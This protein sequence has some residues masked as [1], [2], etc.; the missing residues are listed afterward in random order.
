MKDHD[1]MGLNDRSS[2]VARLRH[3]RDMAIRM[4]SRHINGDPANARAGV[5]ALRPRLVDIHQ[6]LLNRDGRRPMAA[7]LLVARELRRAVF[8]AIGHRYAMALLPAAIDALRGRHTVRITVAD[9]LTG[10]RGR[11]FH[12]GSATIAATIRAELAPA[13]ELMYASWT[14]AERESI[15]GVV[16]DL[17]R[18]VSRW[19]AATHREEFRDEWNSPSLHEEPYRQESG[20]NR[21]YRS[22]T[23]SFLSHHL[24]PELDVSLRN[25]EL[26]QAEHLAVAMADLYRAFED[27]SCPTADR[28]PTALAHL[29]LISGL[30]A[31]RDEVA[32][33]VVFE[34]AHR[35]LYGV[36]R[37]DDGPWVV[38]A[39]RPPL[40][41]RIHER[42]G[43][44][45]A[46]D[47]LPPVTA[48]H[49]ELVDEFRAALAD[50]SRSCRA[51]PPRGGISAADVSASLA[52]VI[53][54]DLVRRGVWPDSVG[55]T[56]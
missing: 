40:T 50:R 35:S 42:P 12:G 36:H 31:L 3:E 16:H 28:L 48:R 51:D 24:D 54:D 43:R 46:V 4:T 8:I 20:V 33:R 30:A 55:I 22:R 14:S 10:A 44:C 37:I 29:P 25:S 53:T 11:Q 18:E 21:P 45:P 19:A 2:A 7:N 56:R 34:P 47:V 23:L 13:R 52:V 32:E 17:S 41:A 5:G 49:Q 39:L 27:A 15:A 26:G 9:R 1:P 6:R 38:S